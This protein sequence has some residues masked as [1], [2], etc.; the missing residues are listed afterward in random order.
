[1]GPGYFFVGGAPKSGTTWVQRSLDLH[2][3]IVCSG[4]GHLHEFIVRPMAEMFANYNVKLSAVG[5]IVYEGQP[6]CPPLTRRDQI[7]ATRAIL[8]LLMGRR[9]KPGARMIGDKTPA[10]AKMID[11]LAVLFPEM[12]FI[13]VLRDP[14]DVAAS[15]LGHVRRIGR[16]EVSDRSSDL[17]RQVVEAAAIDWR[18]VVDRTQTFA[19]TKPAQIITVRY[20]ALIRDPGGELRRLF[21]FLDVETAPT[22]MDEIVQ[23]SRFEAFSGGRTAG[24]ESGSSFF[25]KGVAGDWPNW[26]NDE[27]IAILSRECGALARHAGY[28]LQAP[29]AGST[30]ASG[31]RE[32]RGPQVYL[33]SSQ[34]PQG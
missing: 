15:R 21:D 9:S 24:V 10:N 4:E 29:S 14:R 18:L 17:Y 20:E 6:V 16:H 2:P 5:E 11:D 7:E 3:Q 12:K 34:A 19:E 8:A 22:Q 23:A 1:M 32:A 30:N 31:P 27:A 13:S 28:D 26:L 25:R 33:R